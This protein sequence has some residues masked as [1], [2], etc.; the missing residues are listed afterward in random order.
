MTDQKNR[1]LQIGVTGGIGSGKS[2]VC[3]IFSCLGISVYDADSRA[4][5]LTNADPEIRAKVIELLGSKSYDEHGNY[6]RAFVASL[7][8]K[9]E[10]LLRR[11]NSIIHP[12]VQR[13]TEK[14]VLD[15]QKE[16]YII[17]EAAIMNAA[18]DSNSLDYVIVVQSPVELRIKRIL[19]RD[20]RSEE[21]IRAIIERQVSDT[22][23]NEIA[24]FIIH[25]DE[26]TALIPQVLKLHKLFQDRES[27]II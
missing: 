10:I 13:D 17:K 18:K 15:R 14:W 25:N 7:V 1:P 9:N 3:K 6:N 8:F 22:E 2:I 24:D 11:L 20:S 12:V 5:W 4:K 23:R 19:E 16:S 27:I 26:E 21:E